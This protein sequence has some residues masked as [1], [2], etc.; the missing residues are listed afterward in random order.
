MANRE[1]TRGRKAV[2]RRPRGP[3]RPQ[4]VEG[5]EDVRDSLVD[6]AARLFGERG[7]DAVGIREVATAAGVTPGMISYYFGDKI[8]LLQ[9]VADRVF[10]RL[11]GNLQSLAAAPRSERPLAASL[12][13]FLIETLA[14][15]PWIPQFV[16][17]EIVSRDGPVRQRFVER[18]ASQ[19][20]RVAPAL[21]AQEIAAGRLRRDLDPALA[22]LSLLGQCV[23]PFLSYPIFGPLLGYRLDDAFRERLTAHTARLYLEG[24]AGDER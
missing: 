3:G 15:D 7:Y 23:F 20:A 17:R 9:A 19:A 2:R 4:K 14:R 10:A 1:E 12:I 22:L 8:G 6:A 13:A 11:L 24:T 21:F 16:V 18:F 5:G